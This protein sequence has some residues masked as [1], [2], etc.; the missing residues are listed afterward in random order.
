MPKEIKTD[1]SAPNAAPQAA[2]ET[3]APALVDE[4][5]AAPAVNYPVVGIGA[6]AGGLE[7]YRL[8]FE[9]LPS[10]TGMAF[11]L[12]QHLDPQHPSLL[13]E[14]IGRATRMP[15]V[16]ATDG[17]AVAP[18]RVYTI[19]PNVTLGML[20][21]RLQV[22]ERVIERGR[23][24]PVDEFL[25]SLAQDRGSQAI[26]VV[27][28]G[29]ASDGTA[30]LAAIKA[31]GGLTFA[32]DQASAAYWGMPG[33]AVAAGCAD[34]VLPP[35]E[36]ARELVRLAAHP[37]LRQRAIPEPDLGEDASQALAKV[38]MLLRAR[39]G[40]DFAYYKQSTIRRRIRRR[41][42]V[43]KLER[44]GDYVR[45]L[46]NTPAEL[47]ALF[48][49]LLIN[50]TGFFRDP[51]TFE[52][53]RDIALPR[54]FDACAASAA[55][56]TGGGG[57]GRLPQVRIWVAGCS[58]GEEAYSLAMTLI[59]SADERECDAGLIGTFQIFATDID[60]QAISVARRGVYPERIQ[61]EVSPERL[62]RFFLKVTGG[63]QVS[64]ALRDRCVFAVQNVVKDPPFSRLDLVCC[65]NVLIYLGPMLQKRVLQMFHYA[66]EPEGY[67][68]LGPSES[69]GT[70]AD[71]FA[72]VDQPAKL[73]TKKSVASREGYNFKPRT[74]YQDAL[75]ELPP[76]RLGTPGRSPQQEA[77]ELILARF[78]P[79]G[80]ILT[81]D[82]EIL[83]FRGQ[84][85]RYL[86][87]A[88]GAASLNLLK[89]VRRGLF[90]A[91]RA[92]LLQARDSGVPV[93]KA[94][95]RYRSNGS[96]AQVDLQVLPLH[97][98][99]GGTPC[100][101]VL[102]EEPVAPAAPEPARPAPG[103]AEGAANA[104]RDDYLATLEHELTSTRDYM[105][106]AIAE[107]EGTNEELRS[108][109]EEIQSAN[110]E[111][112][113][114]NEELETAKE[115]LQSTNEELAT[116]NEELESRNAELAA[117]NNDINN[118]LASI[119]LPILMLDNELR[120]RQFTPQAERLLN[121]I[122]TDLG[123]PISNI[124]PNIEVPRLEELVRRVINSLEVESLELQDNA[125]HWY[126][127]RLRPYKTLDHR[128]DGAVITFMEIDE[129]K[130]ARRLR[131]TLADER[132][133][134][135]LVRDAADAI[136]AQGFD[137]GILAWNPAAERFY[138]YPEAAALAL[139]IRELIPADAWPEHERM[140][141]VLRAGQP[142]EP[143]RTRRRT[144]AGRELAV[145][146]VPTALL[147][148]DGKP[149][150]LGTTER[151][152]DEGE[153]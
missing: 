152:F 126:A 104:E 79:A 4:V 145:W 140:L 95:V 138:G 34:L 100:F 52:V 114:T 112:Q 19:P 59:E 109:N 46:Q 32:Q 28:S 121:L 57:A 1:E 11:V 89:M 8:L 119:N 99:A 53:L 98:V 15:V 25:R 124:K 7:A 133:L 153:T 96:E 130:E 129:I 115:E 50:V 135:A 24:L 10:N 44:L 58:T 71:L 80:V 142:M 60:E 63:W 128:I 49:D 103:V 82:W 21:G 111:L 147:G 81:A 41:M 29:T 13:A 51:K 70:Q 23:H 146:L 106:S 6:S 116:V 97:A 48:H 30:G 75:V 72:L 9:E 94:G 144:R 5:S 18:N 16:E 139:N 122:G 118:M 85:G 113:S 73:Y 68:M 87:P 65:R 108:M 83:H 148:A 150:G 117:A 67:L 47:D 77:E 35:R 56:A 66:L 137:G 127:V 101:L 102:F 37:L 3:P 125:G 86:E 31:S 78:S 43:H 93:R 39:T 33:S 149:Y 45:Y 110:E 64:K 27:L 84:T 123:R 26:G 141:E 14:L 40:N 36:I 90:V 120:I 2:P 69:I 76:P 134:A 61:A 17:L 131:V 107:Q 91:L 38:F 136:T 62:R 151:V 42:L 22:L 74:P 92:A 20:H 88:P 143:Y 54:I 12:V 132:R 55:L 105:Q